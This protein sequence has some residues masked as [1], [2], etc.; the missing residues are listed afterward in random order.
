MQILDVLFKPLTFSG[1]SAFWG[2]VWGFVCI[3]HQLWQGKV[4]FLKLARGTS[5][6]GCWLKLAAGMERHIC[7][8]SPPVSLA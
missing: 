5:A 1:N 6:S 7:M 3:L 2:A 8:S 4:A